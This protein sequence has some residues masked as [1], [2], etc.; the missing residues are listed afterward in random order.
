MKPKTKIPLIALSFIALAMLAWTSAGDIKVTGSLLSQVQRFYGATG[1]NFIKVPD[2]LAS[3]LIVEDYENGRD[4]ATVKT[5]NGAEYLNFNMPFAGTLSTVAAAGTGQ[6]TATAIP[7][8]AVWV[9]VSANDGT[10]GVLLPSGSVATCVRI[11]AQ[12]TG[13]SAASGQVET[14]TLLVYGSTSDD[15]T[16]NGLSADA[17]YRQNPATSLT[18]CTANGTAWL[19]Y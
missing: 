6:T 14:N 11:S 15:D 4:I 17:S 13:V 3:A 7:V 18:Y 16:I 8:G 9:T 10:K 2:N 1:T 19:T 5:T 12:A